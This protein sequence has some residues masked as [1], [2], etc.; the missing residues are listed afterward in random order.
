M[1]L[2]RLRLDVR[3]LFQ[4]N[5]DDIVTCYMGIYT[6]QIAPFLR[7]DRQGS[8]TMLEAFHI[9]GISS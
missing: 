9:V 5:N 4:E 2:W 7:M 3:P 8:G 6:A 1:A